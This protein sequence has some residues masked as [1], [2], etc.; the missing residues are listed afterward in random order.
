MD[1][2]VICFK[3]FC[4]FDKLADCKAVITMKK[5]GTVFDPHGLD[6]EALLLA[7]LQIELRRGYRNSYQSVILLQSLHFEMKS[8]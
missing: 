4:L 8:D 1:E 7:C 6:S 5:S 2:I 3:L